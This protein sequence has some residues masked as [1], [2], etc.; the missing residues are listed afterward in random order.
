MTKTGQF[1]VIFSVFFL[2]LSVLI[3][4]IS[5]TRI[6]SVI[7]AYHYAFMVISLALFGLGLGGLYTHFRH[8]KRIDSTTEQNKLFLAIC[9][10]GKGS[11]SIAPSTC[12]S[13]L[14][15]PRS[16][17]NRS[18]AASNCPLNRNVSRINCVNASADGVRDMR[19]CLSMTV[20]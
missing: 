17:V 4:E 18:P 2:S 8:Q 15:R 3:L 6:F 7:L 1:Y 10:T 14:V 5:L 12:Q 20:C 16:F 13:A 19:T 9:A 11:S